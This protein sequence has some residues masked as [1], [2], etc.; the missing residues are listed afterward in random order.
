MFQRLYK[1]RW[2]F[3]VAKN[4]IF[5]TFLK[6]PDLGVLWLRESTKL[7]FLVLGRGG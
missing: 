3:Y 5:Y 6:V 2:L 4:T 7:L 1:L